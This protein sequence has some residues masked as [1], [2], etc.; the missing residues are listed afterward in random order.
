MPALRVKGELSDINQLGLETHFEWLCHPSECMPCTSSDIAEGWKDGF[1]FVEEDPGRNIPGLRR[2]QLGAIHAVAAYLAVSPEEAA[3]VVMPTGTGKTET[4][5]GALVCCQCPRV[6]VLAPSDILRKQLFGKFRTLGC[7][8]DIGVVDNTIVRPRVALIRKGIQD[9]EEC[10]RL[11][12]QS[13][14]LIALPDSLRYFPDEARQ[15][16]VAGCTH[17]FIDEAHHVAAKTWSDIKRMF[18]GKPVVQFTA[19]PFRQDGK[20]LEGRVIFNYKLSE[21]QRDGYFQHIRLHAVEEYGEGSEADRCIAERAVAILR[22]DI[23][24][25]HDHL[26]LA[27]ARSINRA[28]EILPIYQDLAGDLRPV[29]VHSDSGGVANTAAFVALDERSSRIIVCVDMLGEGFDLPNLK[30]AA[31][32]DHHKSLAITLQ[33]IGRFTRTAHGVHEA[34]AV[35]NIAEPRVQDDLQALYAENADWDKILSRESEDTVAREIALLDLVA[36]MRDQGDLAKQL[37]LWNLRP[38][39]SA[40]IYRTD[41]T[42]WAPLGFS[43]LISE[44]FHRWHALSQSDHVLVVVVA[45]EEEVTW[46]KYRDLMDK[47]LELMV[48]H[49]D[50]GRGALFLYC[51]DYDFFRSE[52]MAQA[53]CGENTVPVTGDQLFRVFGGVELPMVR[54]LGASKAGTISF[55]MY[56]GPNVTDGLALVE[57][58]ASELS[59]L[60]GWGY[61]DGNKVT[62]GCSQKKG[63]I[64][65]VHGG[66]ITEWMEWCRGAWDKIA[67]GSTPEADIV[68]GFLRPEPLPVRYKCFPAFVQWGEGILREP[69]ERVIVSI[70]EHEFRAHELDLEVADYTDIGP[71]RLTVQSETCAS[72]YELLVSEDLA[73]GYEYR[74]IDGPE[75]SVQIGR[76]QKRA[77]AERMVRDPV[78]FTY[79]DGSFS[80]NAYIVR[81]TEGRQP[82]DAAVLDARDWGGTDLSVEAQ[83]KER[84]PESIQYRLCRD[85]CDDFSVVF[86]DHSRGEAAD[87]IGIRS[88]GADLMQICLVHC[89]KPGGNAPG[90]RVD[91][92]YELCGQ[93]QKCIRW[94]HSGFSYLVEHMKRREGLW[95]PGA[96]RFVKGGLSDLA[97]LRRQARSA[98]IELEVVLVQPGLS[99]HGVSAPILELLGSTE[100]YLQKTADAKLRVVCSE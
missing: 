81:V 39:C 41:C 15:A 79:V 24:A 76:G 44:R 26:L 25:G 7:L 38:S 99:K 80:Y 57:K 100:L 89:K 40:I 35:V 13:N 17:L 31:L 94:K 34:A 20:S 33:F 68:S 23:A 4:M 72:T 93:G 82:F 77:F 29:I 53:L 61:E 8:P 12:D 87:V 27:R 21:A 9:V 19:T 91:D 65:S 95:T 6:L 36:N 2:P 98:R 48:A 51:S 46:G 11:V 18:A 16:L 54:N 10:K 69:E 14:V 37:S 42:T 47:T 55:T 45:R 52:K 50:E 67:N 84:L 71:L 28:G 70:G 32:H 74:L 90:A 96:S 60:T 5:L 58:S 97:R 3:T 1:R 92:M 83:G 64:W 56:F 86:D 62:W 30:I 49:W 63:K 22:E 78:V 66:P 75:V 88:A 59:N 73:Q 85:V 43:S